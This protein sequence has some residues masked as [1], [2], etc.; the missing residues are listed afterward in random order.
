[1]SQLDKTWE[2]STDDKPEEIHVNVKINGQNLLKLIKLKSSEETVPF[3]EELSFFYDR[4]N[5]KIRKKQKT[6]K[7][8]SSKELSRADI[9]NNYLYNGEWIKDGD[10]WNKNCIYVL[11]SDHRVDKYGRYYC[12]SSGACL[13]KLARDAIFW[14]ST[15]IDIV[16]C[17]FSILYNFIMKYPDIFTAD[18]PSIKKYVFD[19]ESVLE[20][21]SGIKPSDVKEFICSL[22]FGRSVDAWFDT[23]NLMREG[24]CYNF[25]TGIYRE[26]CAIKKVVYRDFK[27]DSK[28][29]GSTFSMY[30][31]ENSNFS[32]L[33]FNIESKIMLIMKEYLERIGGEINLIVHDSIDVFG[34]DWL[35]SPNLLDN[36]SHEIKGICGYEI[37][38]AFKE[39]QIVQLPD[40]RV[41]DSEINSYENVKM[42]FEEHTFKVQIPF[43]FYTAYKE[44]IGR[45]NKCIRYYSHSYKTLIESNLHIKYTDSSGEIKSFIKD[46]VEDAN[47]KMYQTVGIYPNNLECPEDCL[48]LFDGFDVQRVDITEEERASDW[49][50]AGIAIFKSLIL[51]LCENV[52]HYEFLI[53]F[54]AHL[55][56]H[57]QVKP[58]IT[59]ILQSSEEGVGKGLFFQL[60][61]LLLGI[62]YTTIVTDAE[63]AL[64]GN[65]NH[66][67]KNKF[68]TWL[69]EAKLFK[70]DNIEKFKSYIVEPYVS[71]REMRKDT[72]KVRDYNRFILATNKGQPAIIRGRDR[73]IFVTASNSSILL[74]EDTSKF[75]EAMNNPKI[76]RGFYDYLMSV[77]VDANYPFQ[78]RPIS[79]LYETC[80]ASSI[81][82]DI[83]F[84]KDLCI[85]N[86]IEKSQTGEKSDSANGFIT[87]K[88]VVKK[89][90]SSRND[91]RKNIIKFS[92]L[93]M[94]QLFEEFNKY[95]T[96]K[97][98]NYN[99]S[100][101]SF[102]GLF[103]TFLNKVKAN[104]VNAFTKDRVF[105]DGYN[106]KVVYTIHHEF[107]LRYC[108]DIGYMYDDDFISQFFE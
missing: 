44:D 74:P 77:D 33:L 40:E 69:D 87:G 96:S 106:G 25:A 75:L 97:K 72:V 5:E 85:R 86:S 51:R 28:S 31:L 70:E 49:M 78:N 50:I 62:D 26:C 3:N 19:R 13:W 16:N 17:H 60:L 82:N 65:Y 32:L 92:K 18:Y 4:D 95:T 59:V 41:D 71:I 93:T 83:G 91:I 103:T 101:H 38:L 79:T 84:I 23:K 37:K 35:I 27:I 36:I 39:K 88:E 47:I 10:I 81:P 90:S 48:N 8:K 107:I 7:G 105:T 54:I 57:P 66:I 98:I 68:I 67:M 22:M 9:L 64:F 73:R 53:L 80:L 1:M 12:K 61:T 45:E 100:Y 108:R 11:S 52:E 15:T 56:K 42:K 99:T 76:R 102:V 2:I 46:W 43:S 21:Y 20:M 94:D 89:Q 63:N 34:R 14:D 55:F 29:T 58:R 24:S 6:L 104:Y 30:E